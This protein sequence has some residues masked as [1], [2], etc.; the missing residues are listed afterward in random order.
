MVIS[1]NNFGC[2]CLQEIKREDKTTGYFDLEL[3]LSLDAAN[4]I[5]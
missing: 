1:I 5:R 4:A 3:E 2:P